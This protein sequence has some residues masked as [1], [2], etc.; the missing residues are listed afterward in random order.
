[1]AFMLFN[2]AMSTAEFMWHGIF[3]IQEVR[4][5]NKLPT[6]NWFETGKADFFFYF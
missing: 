2:D 5:R 6:F 4:R 1:M 3:R